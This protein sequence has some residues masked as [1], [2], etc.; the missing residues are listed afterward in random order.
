MVDVW[1]ERYQKEEV[2]QTE[3]KIF[4]KNIIKT[5]FEL[6]DKKVENIEKVYP[7]TKIVEKRYS[8]WFYRV[9]LEGFK[10]FQ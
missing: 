7:K 5:A 10:V 8:R 9:V 6:S 3:G 4:L 2:D 1:N